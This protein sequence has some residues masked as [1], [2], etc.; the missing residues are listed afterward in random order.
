[1]SR[2]ETRAEAAE[3]DLVPSPR[4]RASLRAFN[5]FE[6]K[7]LVDQRTAMA[8]RAELAGRLDH[9]ANSRAGSY[10]VWSR[11]YDTRDLRF[12]WEKIEGIRFRRKLRVRHYGRPSDVTPET[13]VWVEVK[14]RVNRV[15]QKRR[16]LL[17]YSEASR[18]CVGEEPRGAAPCDEAVI[19]EVLAM[20]AEFTLRPVMVVG[21]VREPFEGRDEETGLRVTIDNRV[22]GRDRDLELALETENRFVVRPDLSIVEVKV[23]DR[24]PYW[25]TDWIARHNLQLIRMSKYCQSVEVYSRAPRSVF[26]VPEHEDAE[27]TERC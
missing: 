1:M 18:L 27:G 2:G 15:T 8:L 26:H 14:Q 3:G 12:Y 11:Y 20:V 22:R 7:Y 6:L 21:Y 9:D 16:G 25:L 4:A 19:E 23:N 10:T 17:P 13:P 5:R 24:V